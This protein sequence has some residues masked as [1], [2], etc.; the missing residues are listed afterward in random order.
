MLIGSLILSKQTKQ[1]L[2]IEVSVLENNIIK[3]NLPAKELFA[4]LKR[5]SLLKRA[6]I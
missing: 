4:T 3:V 5:S 6:S 1:F 2:I